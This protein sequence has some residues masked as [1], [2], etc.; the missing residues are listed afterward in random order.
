MYV[1]SS[2]RGLKRAGEGHCVH[3]II[4]EITDLGDLV[5]VV[6]NHVKPV[7]CPNKKRSLSKEKTTAG[8]SSIL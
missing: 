6:I 4:V 3:Q 5:E 7:D 1:D 8:F 2:R